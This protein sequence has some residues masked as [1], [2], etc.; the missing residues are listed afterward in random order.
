[1]DAHTL[2]CGSGPTSGAGCWMRTRC[3][4]ALGLRP[5]RAVEFGDGRVYAAMWLWACVLVSAVLAIWAWR[6]RRQEFLLCVFDLAVWLRVLYRYFAMWI[7]ACLTVRWDPLGR[8]QALILL[9]GLP[10]YIG[11]RVE[12]ATPESTPGSTPGSAGQPGERERRIVAWFYRWHDTPTEG[13]WRRCLAR[14]GLSR[15]PSFTLVV[16]PA[17]PRELVRLR[18][19]DV[20]LADPPG[21]RG[22]RTLR[23][24][25]IPDD[26]AERHPPQSEVQGSTSLGGLSLERMVRD[27]FERSDRPALPAA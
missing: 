19:Q 15:V 25:A 1:M 9:K 10:A 26:S 3:D 11:V 4:A 21:V 16:H 20:R 2:R 24:V 12:S 17:G 8:S 13:D 23:L 5:E 6:S 27:V 18:V 7:S 14:F 22:S